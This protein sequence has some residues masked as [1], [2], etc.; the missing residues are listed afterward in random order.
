MGGGGGLGCEAPASQSFLIGWSQL[1]RPVGG[2]FA[3]SQAQFKYP[4]TLAAQRSYIGN[5][6]AGEKLG[7]FSV[8]RSDKRHTCVFSFEQLD[9]K[10]VFWLDYS[11][12]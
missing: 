6:W 4:Q 7:V 9:P 2:A 1:P 12:S 11:K 3:I 5:C 8:V 10:Y